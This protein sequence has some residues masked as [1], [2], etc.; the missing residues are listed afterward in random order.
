MSTVFLHEPATYEDYKGWRDSFEPDFPDVNIADAQVALGVNSVVFAGY[1]MKYK[2]DR[3]WGT[4]S[5]LAG[6]LY[7]A[8]EHRAVI[9]PPGVPREFVKPRARTCSECGAIVFYAEVFERGH[10]EGCVLVG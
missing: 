2:Y 3:V 5:S 9:V 7:S 4:D 10:K 1:T 8:Y 6:A